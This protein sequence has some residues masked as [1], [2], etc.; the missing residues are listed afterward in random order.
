VLDDL[1]YDD[2][3]SPAIGLVP[4]GVSWEDVRDHIKIAHSPLLMLQGSGQYAGVY[5]TGTE[6]VVTEDLGSHLRQVDPGQPASQRRRDSPPPHPGRDRRGISTGQARS[7]A[8]AGRWHGLVAV[9]PYGVIRRSPRP[10]WLVHTVTP[11]W[12]SG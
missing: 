6:A 9:L 11:R 1:E 7:A 8:T 3:D 4:A 12:S 10:G 5:W 2:G